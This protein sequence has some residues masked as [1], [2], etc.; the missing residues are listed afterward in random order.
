MN[1]L[2]IAT[3]YRE[4]WVCPDSTEGP[5]DYIAVTD[6]S[7]LTP[8]AKAA[9]IRVIEYSAYEHLKV[10]LIELRDVED[11]DSLFYGPDAEPYWKRVNEALSR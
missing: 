2:S 10:L 11:Y 8:P 3:K 1:K 9:S 4:F 5:G 7:Q 6:F